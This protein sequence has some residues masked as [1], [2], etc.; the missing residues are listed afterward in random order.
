MAKDVVDTRKEKRSET[1]FGRDFRGRRILPLLVEDVA[2]LIPGAYKGLGKG[3]QFLNDLVDAD[4]L[5]HIVD[6]SDS[7]NTSGQ[8]QIGPQTRAY[9]RYIQS[10]VIV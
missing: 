10:I 3:N 4:C 9:N 7:A 1:E 6:V 8:I 2:G 5:I